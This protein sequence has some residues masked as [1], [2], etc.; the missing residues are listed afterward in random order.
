MNP[1][2][3]LKS[4]TGEGTPTGADEIEDACFDKSPF[5]SAPMVDLQ[6]KQGDY[7]SVHRALL[8]RNPKLALLDTSQ[9]PP[10]KHISRSAGHVLV[11]YL[12]T[13]T[14]HT[15]K[16]I[17]PTTGREETIAKLKTGFEVYATARKYELDGLEELAKEQISLLSKGADALTI[18]DVVNEAY[19][20]STDEDT[21]FPTYMKAIIK[22]AFEDSAAQ[23]KPE[24]HISS[25]NEFKDDIP[26]AK[27]LLRGALEVYREMVKDASITTDP[28]QLEDDECERCATTKKNK[29]DKKKISAVVGEPKVEESVN[30][31]E[32]SLDTVDND[33]AAI[34][35]KRK[36][37]GTVAKEPNIE[38]L[39]A[40]PKPM[41][42][43]EKEEG[44]ATGNTSGGGPFSGGLFSGGSTTRTAFGA[45]NNA[46]V[47]DPPGTAGVAFTPTTEKDALYSK[48]T[49]SFRNIL[50]MGA[51]KRWSSEELRLAD[52]N[53]GRK[54]SGTAN[55][56]R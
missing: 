8:Q 10:L 3:N 41:P 51:Y 39:P 22:T 54:I 1:K 17:G 38:E 7:L 25:E 33:W 55:C 40:R 18:V 6:F 27:T 20:S 52:Y 31:A 14:Y 19:P 56:P 26:T 42:E 9:S 4:T 37:K 53:Q 47:G 43:P 30:R 21:W 12:Y 5:S 16:W 49:Q 34:S 15:L 13:D 44:T 29:K 28:S 35:T 45:T 50:F 48:Q 11:H 23:L 32:P 24:I 46:A 36:E 2:K